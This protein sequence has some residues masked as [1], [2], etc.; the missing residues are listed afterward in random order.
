MIWKFISLQDNNRK[1]LAYLYKNQKPELIE[2]VL[3]TTVFPKW[4][5]VKEK[6]KK[7]WLTEHP[8]EKEGLAKSQI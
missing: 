3:G 5:F 4:Y 7:K 6:K 8:V 1:S 2:M